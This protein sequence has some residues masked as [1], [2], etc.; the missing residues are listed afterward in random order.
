MRIERLGNSRDELGEGPLW[1]VKEQRLYWID[2]NSGA[3][4]R[5]DARGEDRKT[6][7]LPEHIG[8]MCLR[9]LPEPRFRG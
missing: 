8:S 3:M 5:A 1:N 9:S 6:W 2:S 7:T 4:H